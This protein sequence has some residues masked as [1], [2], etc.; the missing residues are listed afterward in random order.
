MVVAPLKARFRPLAPVVI[1]SVRAPLARNSDSGMVGCGLV[2]PPV[3]LRLPKLE[4]R[5]DLVLEVLAVGT[6]GAG[7]GS[8]L[9]RW[10]IPRIWAALSRRGRPRTGVK[11]RL[12]KGSRWT[13]RSPGADTI[14]CTS[15]SP[16]ERT[17]N[18]ERSKS[19]S[20]T[21]STLVACCAR[22]LDCWS[23]NV[24]CCC[25]FSRL[26]TLCGEGFVSAISSISAYGCTIWFVLCC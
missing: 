5:C 16:D 19:S 12:A 26:D 13:E 24:D 3:A 23:C 11:P 2:Y 6:L 1:L 4:N 17:C 14:E 18:S 22:P 20:A 25:C 7:M 9:L 21:G 10:G 15:D 8:I